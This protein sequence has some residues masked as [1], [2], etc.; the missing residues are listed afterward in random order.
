MSPS[1]SSAW[2]VGLINTFMMPVR[3]VTD[4]PAVEPRRVI[5]AIA[6]PTWS[7]L[8][9]KFEATGM[10]APMAPASSPASR[11]PSRTVLTR[12]SVAC[13]AERVS[14]PYAFIADTTANA[15]SL[16]SPR[17]AAAAWPAA[18]KTS[19]AST[20]SRI[21]ADVMKN[22]ASANS[23]ADLPTFGAILRMSSPHA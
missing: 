3:L 12:M 13:A 21:P 22:N 23:L 6:A 10:I 7:K 11:F 8:T 9:P 4:S 18:S 17:P 2:D 19:I 16:V 15:T 1:A 20:E 5:A 14:E